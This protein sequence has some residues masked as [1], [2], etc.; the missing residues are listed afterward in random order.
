MPDRPVNAGNLR[1]LTGTSACLM[2][3]A[4]TGPSIAAYVLL[5]S[6][7]RPGGMIPARSWTRLFRGFSGAYRGRWQGPS[8][9]PPQIAQPEHMDIKVL[10]YPQ[11]PVRRLSVRGFQPAHQLPRV[12]P[13]RLA[14]IQRLGVAQRLYN[15]YKRNSILWL[16][17]EE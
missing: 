9:D 7:S 3:C 11:R 12:R 15:L 6:G 13:V 17:A 1:S 5:S 16:N 4:H 14:Q 8:A 2:T 10:Y